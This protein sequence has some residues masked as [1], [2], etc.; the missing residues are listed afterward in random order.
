MK[1]SAHNIAWNSL[2]LGAT[3]A[4]IIGIAATIIIANTPV[5]VTVAE[6]EADISWGFISAPKSNQ[7]RFVN[8]LMEE[9]FAKPRSYDWNGNKF[10]FSMQTTSESPAEIMARLQ[11]SFVRNGVNKQIYL[12][13]A[14]EI[15]TLDNGPARPSPRELSQMLGNFSQNGEFFTGGIVP[16]SVSEDH[17]SM[18]GA[19]TH[20]EAQTQVDVLREAVS[21]GNNPE[22]I[23]KSMRFIEGWKN[24]GSRM[25]TVTASWSD[26]NLD[27]K[28]L[29]QEETSQ[30]ISVDPNIPACVGCKREMRFAGER[31]EANYV[32]TIF[33]GHN[34]VESTS[35]FYKQALGS[36]GWKSTQSADVMTEL[37][38]QGYLNNNAEI[39]TYARGDEFIS[40]LVYP[41]PKTG[42][43]ITHVIEAP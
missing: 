7:Q 38:N 37:Q 27:F 11:Q 4:T 19:L 30:N 6:A 10:F 8:S 17:F 41:D 32:R 9:G 15:P 40:V 26:E 33:S 28:K 3:F 21:A 12:S 20:K 2:K 5:D 1:I 22:K 16:V 29:R 35:S 24:K 36:R 43:S 42:R 23:V 14:P 34:T 25:T 13:E 31:K 18:T 39:T